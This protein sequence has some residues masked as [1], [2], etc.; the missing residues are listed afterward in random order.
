MT[1]HGHRNAV[2]YCLHWRHL[3]RDRDRLNA[4]RSHRNFDVKYQDRLRTR[5]TKHV[6]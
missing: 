6:K 2:T 1:I 4:H 5:N 3:D